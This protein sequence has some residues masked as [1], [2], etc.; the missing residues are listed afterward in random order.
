M[1]IQKNEKILLIQFNGSSIKIISMIEKK[2]KRQNLAQ[3]FE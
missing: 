1:M 2:L 3:T